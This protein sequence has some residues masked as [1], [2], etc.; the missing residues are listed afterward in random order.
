MRASNSISSAPSGGISR[1]INSPLNRSRAQVP[2]SWGRPTKRRKAYS[3]KLEEL[4]TEDYDSIDVQGQAP[5]LTEVLAVFAVKLAGADIGGLDVATLDPD[6]VS[7]LTAVFGDMTA[8]T[9]EVET[10][11]HPASGNR[12]TWTEKILHI[13]ITPKTADDMRT[14]YSFTPY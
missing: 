14:A 9:T 13:T 1:R 7:K 10:I 2:S 11:D 5:D 12:E 6:R 4:Q 8:I 3:A